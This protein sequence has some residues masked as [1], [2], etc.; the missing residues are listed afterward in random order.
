MLIVSDMDEYFLAC[1][2]LPLCVLLGLAHYINNFARGVYFDSPSIFY[3]SHDFQVA[4][5]LA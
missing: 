5:L 3:K 1:F 2:P 4:N